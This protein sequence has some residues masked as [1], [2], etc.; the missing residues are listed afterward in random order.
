[1][2]RITPAEDIGPWL[3]AARGAAGRCPHCGEGR[4]FRA[5]LKQVEACA[6]CGERY[7][8]IRADD[9]PAWLTIIVVGHIVVGLILGI[10]PYT[11]WPSWVG[12]IGWSA[13]TIGLTLALLPAAKGIFISVIRR[14]G[15]VGS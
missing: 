14:T 4:L 6:L 7:G 13:L 9:G 12:I 15:A 2:T 5:Y 1:M 11:P 10:E 8:H 3:A